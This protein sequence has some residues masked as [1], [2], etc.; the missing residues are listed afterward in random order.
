MRR[1]HG[2]AASL[3]VYGVVACLVVVLDRVTKTLA[4]DALGGGAIQPFLPGV[5]DFRLVYNTG[6]A[7]G[8]LEGG[9]VLFL[10]IAAVAVVGMVLYLIFAHR[11]AVLQVLGL[12]MIAG[13]AV[14]N[15]ID[16]A[17]SGR[18]VDF[19]HTLFID[20]PYFNIADSAI[21][22]GVILFMVALLF[23]ERFNRQPPFTTED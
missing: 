16:R 19:I 20:F 4:E 17:A 18:V 13:G 7:W 6:A 9:R 12:G 21:T 14:G 15:A 2:R 3:A 10:G 23:G 22:V 1:R 8:M 11:H 5:I